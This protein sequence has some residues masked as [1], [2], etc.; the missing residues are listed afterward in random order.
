MGD[1]ILDPDDFGADLS[2]LHI[3]R[4]VDTKDPKG[5]GRVR[6]EIPGVVDK[7]GWARP[8]AT[9][10]GGTAQRGAHWVPNEGATVGVLFHLADLDSPY[11]LAGAPGSAVPDVGSEVPQFVK[12]QPIADR[13]KLRVIETDFFVIAIDDRPAPLLPDGETPDLDANLADPRQRLLI[14]FKGNDALAS[15][16]DF[17]EIDGVSRAVQVSGTSAVRILSAGMIELNANQIQFTVQGVTRR[18]GAVTKDI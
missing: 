8:L 6:V 7:S 3:G 15:E 14:S 12:D 16:D 11:Y 1:P 13:D 4:V 2:V 10:I 17:I 5:V 9:L 18:V